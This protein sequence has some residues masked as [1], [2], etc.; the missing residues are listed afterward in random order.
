MVLHY[1]YFTMQCLYQAGSV[2]SHA[3][4]CKK[5][6]FGILIKQVF[7]IKSN[8]KKIWLNILLRNKIIQV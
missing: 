6:Y 4:L 8:L 1:Y 5:K 3:Y 7:F 2:K